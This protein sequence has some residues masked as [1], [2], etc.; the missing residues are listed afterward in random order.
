MIYTPGEICKIVKGI[1]ARMIIDLAERKL[2]IPFKDTQGPR[3][4]RLYDKNEIIKIMVLCAVRGLVS[5]KYQKKI[6]DSFESIKTNRILETGNEYTK[7]I[8][9]IDQIMK[10]VDKN[11]V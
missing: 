11:F 2:I 10:F 5:H 1:N 4:S 8:V 3:T 7:I 6:S 9:Y